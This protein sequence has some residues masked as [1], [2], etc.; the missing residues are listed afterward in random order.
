MALGDS[1]GPLRIS[2][3]PAPMAADTFLIACPS[4]KFQGLKAT[5]TP[6][7]SRITS[8]RTGGSREGTTR[9]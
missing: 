4:G 6:T 1:S 8:W 2:V 9:P 7:G 3:Q 5:H